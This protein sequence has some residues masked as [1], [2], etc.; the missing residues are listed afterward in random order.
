M[1]L[2]DYIQTNVK[3]PIHLNGEEIKKQKRRRNDNWKKNTKQNHELNEGGGSQVP[4]INL[5][6]TFGT[7][8]ALWREGQ[9]EGKITQRTKELGLSNYPTIFLFLHESHH[10]CMIQIHCN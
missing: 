4:I 2:Y 7:C 5:R 1:T 6:W 9:N 8:R 3:C 10:Q